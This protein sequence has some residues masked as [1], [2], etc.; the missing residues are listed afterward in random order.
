MQI[1][2]IISILNCILFISSLYIY[3]H[4]KELNKDIKGFI[5]FTILSNIENI[6]IK[7]DIN[8]FCEYKE[9]VCIK[10]YLQILD[11]I[12]IDPEYGDLLKKDKYLLFSQ[13]EKFFNDDDEFNQILDTKYNQLRQQMDNEK[14]DEFD[15]IDRN[16]NEKIDITKDLLNIMK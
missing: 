12:E 4:K 16:V 15:I 13:V 14:D 3:N 7:C 1:I 11:E 6:D 8:S 5:F 9:I 10:M 2:I